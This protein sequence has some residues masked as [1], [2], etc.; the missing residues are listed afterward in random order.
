MSRRDR[1]RGYSILELIV[2]LL[3]VMLLTG[4]GV[5]GYRVF[6]TNLADHAARQNVDRVVQAE[7]GWAARNASWTAVAADLSVGRGLTVTGSVSTAPNVVSVAVRDG[8]EI[9]IAAR[10]ESG[11]CQGKFI[12]DPLVDGAEVWSE[13]PNGL[14]CSGDS[15]LAAN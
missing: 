7:R 9:G 11:A 10:S 14:P 5:V 1:S 4:I 3:L 2:T 15:V 8:R 6:S 13:I 12:G